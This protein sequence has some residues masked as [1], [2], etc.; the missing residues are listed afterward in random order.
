MS[1]KLIN[2]RG[3]LGE[4][5]KSQC[6][7]LPAPEED[8]FIYHTWNIDDKNKQTQEKE[9]EKFMRFVDI[10]KDKKIIFISTYSEKENWYNH[11]KQL[12]EAY[13]SLNCKKGIS[14]RIPT[15]IG[16]GILKKLKDASVTAY[17]D[18]ELITRVQAAKE[19][20]NY[21]SYNG[22]IKNFRI[23]GEKISAVTIESIFKDV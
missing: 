19:V 11:Y 15:I 8:I 6:S 7:R 21:V 10:N 12:S 17:G 22:L 23:N 20:L 5:L 18:M 13:L 1:I 2:G 9:Y 16:K 14:L 4:E 3:Q